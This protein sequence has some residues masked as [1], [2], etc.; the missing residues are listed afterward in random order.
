M[1]D[2]HYKYEISNLGWNILFT[3]NLNENKNLE[4]K[5]MKMLFG[6]FKGRQGNRYII[7]LCT[8]L[9]TTLYI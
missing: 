6:K 4:T 5:Y 1:G 3:L 2:S 9:L 7:A 8:H